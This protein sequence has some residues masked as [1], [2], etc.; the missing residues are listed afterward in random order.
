MATNLEIYANVSAVDSDRVAQPANYVQLDLIS[1]KLIWSAGDANV[2]DGQ[3]TPSSAELDAAATIITTTDVEIDKLLLL[4]F[5][6][7]GVEL[8]E[9]FLAGSGDNQHVLNLSFDGATASEPTLEGFDDNTHALANSH[10]LGNGTPANSMV[11]GVVTTL[12]SP[13]AGWSGLAIAGSVAPNV[14][15]LNGGSGAFGSAT[16]VYVNLK[17]VVPA[18]YTTPFSEQPVITCRYT[19]S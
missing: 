5:S 17:I 12:A 10:V 3:D 9:V 13:G 7:T 6:D 11:K 16:E 8:K 4:D 19:F 18:N 15:P 2:A 14:L 1:D